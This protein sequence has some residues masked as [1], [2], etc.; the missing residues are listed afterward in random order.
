MNYISIDSVFA[1]LPPSLIEDIQRSREYILQSIRDSNIK[2]NYERQV[3]TLIV[4]DHRTEL[5]KDLKY[6][7]AIAHLNGS[8][9]E[10]VNH[11]RNTSIE[12]NIERDDDNNVVTTTT[13][14]TIDVPTDIPNIDYIQRIQ[15]LGV[16]NNYKLFLE[17]P[18]FSK[19]FQIL[20]LTNRAFSNG[21]HCSSCPNLN[22]NCQDFYTVNPTRTLYT[23]IKDG[24]LCLSYLRFAKV[25]GSYVIP[26]DPD[27]K[28]ALAAYLKYRYWEDRMYEDPRM[29]NMYK[30]SQTEYEQLMAKAKGNYIIRS[31]NIEEL[32]GQDEVLIRWARN[33]KVFDNLKY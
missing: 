13:V 1:Y 15:H 6:I 14:T 18:V 27:I 4:K 22:S 5:P 29:V 31:T 17:S 23:S 10:V 7:E 3:C 8:V 11:I 24:V 25:D 28:K 33:S 16:I 21:L 2:T 19:N 9:D 12:R 30:M 26:D 32:I 20:R